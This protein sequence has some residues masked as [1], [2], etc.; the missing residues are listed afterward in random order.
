ME[1]FHFLKDPNAIEIYNFMGK[2]EKDANADEYYGNQMYDAT[3]KKADVNFMR[4]FR[5]PNKEA[6]AKLQA[7]LKKSA[8]LET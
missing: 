2:F 4:Y 8:E 1:S 7:A 6:T 3:R 5:L